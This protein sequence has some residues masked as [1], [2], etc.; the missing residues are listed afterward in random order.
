MRLEECQARHRLA[1]LGLRQQNFRREFAIFAETTVLQSCSRSVS[2]VAVTIDKSATALGA[3]Y[4]RLGTRIGKRKAV[5]ATARKIAIYDSIRYSITYQDK[6]AAAFD[7][8]HRQRVSETSS[9]V[10]N[11]GLCKTTVET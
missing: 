8:R 11:N 1:L 6:D 10:S 5:T 9:S 2:L 4:R 7:E 3:F